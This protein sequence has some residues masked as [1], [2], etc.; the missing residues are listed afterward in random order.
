MFYEQFYHSIIRKYV[1]AFGNLFNNIVIQRHDFSDNKLQSISVPIA[2]GPKES[3]LVRMR[4]DPDLDS[5]VA[6]TLPRIGFQIT[7]FNYEPNRKLSSTLKNIVLDDND[8]KRRKSQ[9]VPVPYDI[10]FQLS[11]FVRNTDDGTQIVEQILPYFRPEFTTN[12]NII[13]EMKLSVDTPVV[14][15]DVSIEEIYEGDLIS[16]QALV[17]NLMFS[18]KGYMYGPVQSKGIIT[19]A[20]LDFYEGDREDSPPI[21]QRL[22]VTDQGTILDLEGFG[23]DSSV[24]SSSTE[25]G[26]TLITTKQIRLYDLDGSNY[27]GFK[28]PDEV[29]ENIVWCLPPADGESG[30]V[31]QTNG[32]GVL[33]WVNVSLEEA[34]SEEFVWTPDGDKRTLTG[35]IEAGTTYVVRSAEFQSSLLV[36]NLASFTPAL[37]ASGLPTTTLNWDI[38]ATGFSV[39]VDNPSDFTDSYISDVVSVTQTAGTVSVLANF[40]AGAKSNPPAGGVDWTQTFSTDVDA[41]IRTNSTT[42][43]GGSAA[44]TVAFEVTSGSTPSTYGSTA[45]WTIN[46]VTPNVTI[47]MSNLSGSTFLQTYVSTAYT[48]GVTGVTNLGN[49]THTVTP[50][51]GNVSNLSGSGTFTFTTP[52][53][54]DNVGGRTL[55]LSSDLDRPV[56]V[57]GTAYTVNDTASDT[58]L[59]AAFT[60][61][62]FWI[63]TSAAGTPPL[64]ADIIDG[65]GFESDVTVLGNQQNTFVGFVAN[66]AIVPQTFWLSVKDS[67]SQP[68]SFQAG[69]SPS[70]LA[71]ISK[72]NGSVNLEPDTPP[73]GYVAE[74]YTLHGITLQ[75]GDTYLSIT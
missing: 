55:A 10:E 46:W 14:L 30:Q 50:T 49:V 26:S 39:N 65:A 31:L 33:T 47:S 53:H 7:S 63:F 35:F 17:F 43:S 28:A 20:V 2:Y 74:G 25:L 68:T 60:Y 73:A 9:F 58:S 6:I 37:S 56:D 59:S 48:V 12:V 36:L 67:V 5:E 42:I 22:T 72:T 61:P 52:I 34:G 44:A 13:P 38:A 71:N 3:F 24:Q 15:T 62:S 21:T 23:F 66:P 57:T 54:K 4:Q 1:I 18:L 32:E 11:V 45:N 41:F 8:N 64:R 16:R 19:R 69:S 70:L 51:G 75:P 29:P 27:V 40:T